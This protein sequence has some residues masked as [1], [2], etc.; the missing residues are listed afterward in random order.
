METLQ[1]KIQLMESTI[2]DVAGQIDAYA[3]KMDGMMV[4]IENNDIN[5]KGTFET[6]RGNCWQRPISWL[7]TQQEYQMRNYRHYDKKWEAT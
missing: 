5:V 1:A 6:M 2:M 4:T 3:T 7:R